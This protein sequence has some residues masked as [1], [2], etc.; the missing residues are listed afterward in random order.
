MSRLEVASAVPEPD[1]IPEADS[2]LDAAVPSG[3]TL[4]SGLY[5]G[6]VRHRRFE[7]IRNDFTYSGFWLYL[8]LAE[9]DAVFRGRWLWSARRAALMR[10]RR[11]DHLLF[12]DDIASFENTDRPATVPSPPSRGDLEKG[13]YGIRPE[14]KTQKT[15]PPLDESVRSLVELSTGRRPRGP[16]R[17]LTQ[18]RCFGYLMNPVSFY[19]C[20][21][22]ASSRVETVVAE[23][24]NTPWGERHC[25]VLDATRQE[26][27]SEHPAEASS[28]APFEAVRIS[29]RSTGS[30]H[31]RFEHEKRFHVSPFMQ[32]DMSYRWRI[33]EPDNSLTVQIENWQ[34][35]RR[36]FDCTFHLK[37]RPMT[38]GQLARVLVRHPFMT[39]K[40]VGA[41]YW[42]A[43]KLW[44][45]GCPFVS[46]PNSKI[47]EASQS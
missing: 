29:S 25:Y 17:L 31:L 21:D 34:S 14:R 26:D 20:F 22:E 13:S 33:A 4:A 12:P 28:F 39:G 43:L 35:D 6:S 8:D 47:Q 15:L 24:N 40:F 16:I 1:S 42:Q 9:I 41:I 3:K 30:R 7:P 45:K 19:Y 44:W 32:M 10:F 18:L 5:V 36:L 38:G 11:E 27:R 23:V 37:R 2:H 46:H